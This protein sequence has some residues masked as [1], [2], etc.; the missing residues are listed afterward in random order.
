[1]SD[2]LGI[3]NIHKVPICVKPDLN[4]FQDPLGRV[5]NN[6]TRQACAPPTRNSEVIPSAKRQITNINPLEISFSPN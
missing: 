4:P 6:K 3:P 5:S 1:M 2:Y